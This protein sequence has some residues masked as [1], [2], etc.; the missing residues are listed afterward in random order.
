[1]GQKIPKVGKSRQNQAESDT[2][3]QN[4]VKPRKIRKRRPK[5]GLIRL[6]LSKYGHFWGTTNKY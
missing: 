2:I 6:Y 4:I 5:L 3:E 1:M